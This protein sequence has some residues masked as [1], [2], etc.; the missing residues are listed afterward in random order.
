MTQADRPPRHDFKTVAGA[1]RAG[2]ERVLLH[3]LPDGKRQGHE[4]VAR[5]PR[6]NDGR[7]G[8]FSINTNTGAWADFATGDKG[9]DL[10]ALVAYLDGMTQAE[11]AARL[12][13]FLGLSPSMPPRPPT[14]ATPTKADASPVVPVPD[15]APSPP[16]AHSKHGPPAA[17]WIYRDAEGRALFQVCRFDLPQ[18][19]QVLPLS[20]WRERGALHW[21]WKGLPSP[22]PLYGLDALATRPDALVIVCEGEKDCDAAA[23]LLRDCVAVTS[24]NGCKSAKQAEWAPLQGRRVMVWPD[25]DQAGAGYAGDVVELARKAGAASV[26]VLPLAALARIRDAALP[27][28]WGAA[29]AEAEGIEP[30]ALV[31]LVAEVA[32][33]AAAVSASSV[34][35]PTT[36]T[37]TAGVP[38][39]FLLVEA[40][41]ES[42]RKPGVYYLPRIRDRETGAMVEGAPE[43]ICS[44]LRVEA[45]TRDDAGSEWGRLLVFPDRD[46]HEH[47]WAMPSA[48]MA[49]DGAELRET[50]LAEG[51][52]IT[53]DPRQRG[54]L[55]EYIQA[56]ETGRFARCV[57]RTGWHGP[58]YVLPDRTLGPED[59]EALVFQSATP[60]GSQ[61]AEAG[62]LEQWCEYVAK[63][64]AGNSR[65]VLALSAAF[66]AP[67]LE[68]AGME[69]G[70]LH[71]RGPS[72]T[73]KTTALAVASSVYGPPQYR[74][75]WRTTDNGLEALAALHSDALLPLDEI[76]QL[77]PKHAAVAA[78]LLSNGQGKSRARRDGGLRAPLQ[79][80]LLFLS[81]GESSL[82]DLVTRGGGQ[83]RAG[84]EVRTIDLSADAGQGLGLFDR[85]PAGIAPGAF[86]EQLKGAAAIHYGTALPAFLRV[87]VADM[88]RNRRLLRDFSTGLV[89]Q[90]LD[91]DA[92]GQ[93][94]RVAQRF[95]LLAAAGEI[96]TL[97]RITGWQAGEAKAAA[98]AC[99]RAWLVARGGPGEAEPREMVRQVQHFI[100]THSEG[101]F[102]PMERADDDRAPKTVNRAGYRVEC[103]EG[104]EHWV[105][106]ETW[107]REVCAG[108]DPIEVARVLA[109]RDLLKPEGPNCFSRRER[110]KGSPERARVYRLLPGL[111]E[112]EP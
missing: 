44:P 112:V 10:V 65:L 37:R 105:L 12:A 78:Y 96:A 100:G 17:M 106:T 54:R 4:Y 15:D 97:H 88:E 50:L 52:E 86:A 66:A 68:L 22:R 9:G 33:V 5:N 74:R 92:A 24:P 25:A 108:Y 87:L 61:V 57:T 56:S 32:D 99:F 18:G 38:L 75:E 110:I 103:S 91:T 42:E 21:R 77:D 48:M 2:A 45:V 6:R 39:S 16:R 11:A 62:S 36:G 20:L 31:Q 80:R 40:G 111:L 82:A 94:R 60:G 89:D 69:G 13:E 102:T 7:A 30:T 34:G 72:S 51:L 81:C 67:C 8:S 64:C 27:Q 76:G 63:P 41:S 3:W 93:V 29:D 73:G 43:W 79:W 49:R 23:R 107:R 59:T 98:E 28:G 101:R 19:K 46:H 95:S 84:M 1:A 53:T 83:H 55:Q 90:L 26:D 47:R 70:G 71:L 104:L 85:V 14:P 58:T 35:S 109:A